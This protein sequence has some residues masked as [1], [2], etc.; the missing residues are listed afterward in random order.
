MGETEGERAAGKAEVILK[1]ALVGDAPEAAGKACP[2][3]L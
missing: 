2:E 3:S 1:L